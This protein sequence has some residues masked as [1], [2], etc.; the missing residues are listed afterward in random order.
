MTSRSE[1]RKFI[2]TH[3]G[4]PAKAAKALGVNYS[5]VRKWEQEPTLMLKYLLRITEATNC[6]VMDVVEAVEAQK[7]HNSA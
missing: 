5:T 3:F 6:T 4:N 2:D 1:I 7:K